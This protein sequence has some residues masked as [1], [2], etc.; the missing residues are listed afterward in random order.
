[1][2]KLANSD[3]MQAFIESLIWYSSTRSKLLT[4][5]NWFRFICGW[6]ITTKQS[7]HRRCLV[8]S[9]RMV[10]GE[11]NVMPSISIFSNSYGLI[12]L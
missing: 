1:M 4:F 5:L 3:I 10:G 8:L 7:A 9:S 6:T 2:R 12:N 11:Q